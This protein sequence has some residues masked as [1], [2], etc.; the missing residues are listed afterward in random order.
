[1]SFSRS[2]V[3]A[4][5]NDIANKEDYTDNGF[6]G[7]IRDYFREQSGGQFTLDFDVA[8]QVTMTHSYSY[9]GINN[10]DKAPEMIKEAC[11]GVDSL[12]N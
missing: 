7:S 5:Y 6:N 2:D 4:L 1:M 3:K 10:E 11:Q 12:I 9:Y 8:G